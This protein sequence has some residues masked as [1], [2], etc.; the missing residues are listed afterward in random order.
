MR[1]KGL[2][3]SECA[4]K[5]A[6]AGTSAGAIAGTGLGGCRRRGQQQ[7]PQYQAQH[8]E[9]EESGQPLIAY[10]GADRPALVLPLQLLGML[11]R[12]ARARLPLAQRRRPHRQRPP[13]GQ[14][15]AAG[16]PER[17]TEAKR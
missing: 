3:L 14:L 4:L 11:R 5:A 12:K 10:C 7:V 15:R 16:R 2:S 13:Q 8:G 6:T 9:L 17:T 1:K